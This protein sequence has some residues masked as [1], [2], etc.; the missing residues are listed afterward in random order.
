MG[1]A[2]D[3]LMAKEPTASGARKHGRTCSIHH[4]APTQK[5]REVPKNEIVTE[6]LKEAQTKSLGGENGQN[7][8]RNK[9]H[10]GEPPKGQLSPASPS[11]HQKHANKK[12]SNNP[13]RNYAQWHY[14]QQNPYWSRSLPPHMPPDSPYYQPGW[15]SAKGRG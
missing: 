3:D 2:L 5:Q 7:T 10:K 1:Q 9:Q 13:D 15:G 11:P 4:A 8:N 6:A 12:H 14:W